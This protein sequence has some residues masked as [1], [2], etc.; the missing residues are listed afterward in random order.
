MRNMGQT[1]VAANRIFVQSGIKEEFARR[2]SERLG[3][4]K[5]G[6]GMEEGVTVGSLIQ[7]AALEKV[8]R[9]VTDA[10]EKGARVLCGGERLNDNT[11]G[12]NFH[13]PTVL[14][15]ADDSMLI[16][17]EET[18]GPVAAVMPFDTEEEV[19]RRA[20]DTIYGLAGYYYTR[21][22]GRVMRLAEK[23]EYGIMGA[24]DGMPSTAQAPFGGV[25]ES[26]V[27]REGGAEGMEEYLD[28][29]YVSLGGIGGWETG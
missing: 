19:I 14:V 8:E 27:G 12:G 24:N 1:C 29:K 3:Q 7:A 26:G 20:N 17:K 6:D 2:L 28:T 10:T 22:V 13:A 15:D 16:A 25:K 5:V 11:G 9:H 4:M 21:D 23:L 18:F